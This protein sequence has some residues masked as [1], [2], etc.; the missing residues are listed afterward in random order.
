[1]EYRLLIELSDFGKEKH[2]VDKLDLMCSR[3]HSL[4][5]NGLLYEIEG[6][7]KF[8]PIRFIDALEFVTSSMMEVDRS[9]ANKSASNICN[10]PNCK[11]HNNKKTI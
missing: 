1:M 9:L 6:T 10:D 11:I 3:P 5:D 4:M 7:M 2:K 8:M